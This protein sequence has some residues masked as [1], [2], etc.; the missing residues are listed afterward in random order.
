MVRPMTTSGCENSL[1]WLGISLPTNG[2]AS[3]RREVGTREPFVDSSS[4][5]SFAERSPYETLL[6]FDNTWG[7]SEHSQSRARLIIFSESSSASFSMI[8]AASAAP[9]VRVRYAR[10]W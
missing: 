5:T 1:V 8:F 7:S 6:I 3:R 2:T 10:M 9:L 4:D